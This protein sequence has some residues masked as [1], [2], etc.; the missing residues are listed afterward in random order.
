MASRSLNRAGYMAVYQVP[1]NE[2][3]D[4]PFCAH[5]VIFGDVIDR[6]IGKDDS[7]TKRV[8]GLVTLINLYLMVGVAQFQADSEIKTGGA[9]AKANDFHDMFSIATQCQQYFTSK[10][11]G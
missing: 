3:V 8:V 1:V 10:M 9:T 2:L 11:F 4:D 6:L 7:P 5:G